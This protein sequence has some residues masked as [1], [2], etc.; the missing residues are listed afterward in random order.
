MYFND[1]H[2][3]VYLLLGFLGCIAGQTIGI[4]NDRFANHKK[5]FSREA[6]KEIK[7]NYEA[8]YI[9]MTIT[10]ILYIAVLYITGIDLQNW[11]AN[12]DLITYILLIPMLISVFM[13]D[14]KHEIIP[15]RIVI[16]IL[17][18]GLI[19]TFANGVFNPNGTSIALDR[20][21]GML[22]GGGIFLIITLIGGLIAGKEAMGMGDV[23]LVGVLGLIFGVKSIIIVSVTS[24]LIGAIISILILLFRIKKPSE[25]IPFGPF[26]V[27]AAFIAMF[28]PEAILFNG[29]WWF[30]S[31]EWF[32]KLISN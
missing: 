18:I 3:V 10:A 20:V 1:I 17:E 8:H 24:F 32:L 12:I 31:G 28:V 5:I 4:L 2:I 9:I 22:V 26:I 29:L 7:I 14:V 21:L 30:F 11:Y 27:I 13:I 25:Y 16:N 6:L 15:N 23:K 19:S